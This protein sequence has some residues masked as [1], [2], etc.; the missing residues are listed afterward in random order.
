MENYIYNIYIYGDR[1]MLIKSFNCED[2]LYSAGNPRDFFCE[3]EKVV[4]SRKF[5]ES[6]IL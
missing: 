5:R 6:W 3:F 1:S 4:F 2:R